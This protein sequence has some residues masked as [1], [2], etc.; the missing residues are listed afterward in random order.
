MSNNYWKDKEAELKKNIE[1][2]D[3]LK[4]GM[5]SDGWLN[6]QIRINRFISEAQ[7]EQLKECLTQRDKELKELQKPLYAELETIGKL[8][9]KGSIAMTTEIFF[10]GI[11]NNIDK[12]IAKG[13]MSEITIEKTYNQL[14][15]ELDFI[16]EDHAAHTGKSIDECVSKRCKDQKEK[17]NIITCLEKLEDMKRAKGK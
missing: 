16:E 4:D 11:I 8:K 12:L 10:R 6:S 2:M 13:Q 14:L 9:K 1:R 7:L 17:R 5:S 3:S 15:E